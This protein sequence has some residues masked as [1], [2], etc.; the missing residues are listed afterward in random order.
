[1]AITY[2]YECQKCGH[3]LEILQSIKDEPL[4]QCV[5]CQELALKRIVFAVPVLTTD[6]VKT[7]EQ[8]ASR[9]EKAW[10]RQEVEER[11]AKTEK[12]KKEKYKPW[13]RKT[14]KIDTSLADLAPNVQIKDGKI[15]SSEPLSAKAEKYLITGQR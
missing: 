2:E 11:R 12:P 7:L 4:K 9:N 8:Q 3:R 13:W 14:E 10:G 15:V 6:E 1:M 5:E